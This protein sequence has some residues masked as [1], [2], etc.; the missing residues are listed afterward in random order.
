MNTKQN[1]LAEDFLF[2]INSLYTRHLMTFSNDLDP[3]EA[4]H[5]VWPHLRSKLFDIQIIR[6]QNNEFF[7][8]ILKGK[9]MEKI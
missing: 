5:F 7:V 2:D 4:P 3:V 8:Q 9:R 6:Q 1:L